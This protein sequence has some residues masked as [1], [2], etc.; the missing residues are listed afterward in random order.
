MSASVVLVAVSVVLV[1]TATAMS[2]SYQ[3]SGVSSSQLDNIMDIFG[4]GLEFSA[5]V[6]MI[7]LVLLIVAVL[8]V[9]GRV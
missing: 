6:P 1:I 5:A 4:T 3:N 9:W 2:L 7:L 8:G